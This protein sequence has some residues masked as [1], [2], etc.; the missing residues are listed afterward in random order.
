MPAKSTER[1]FFSFRSNGT[2]DERE[3]VEATVEKLDEHEP[4]AGAAAEKQSWFGTDTDLQSMLQTLGFP[5]L[6]IE[7][8]LSTLKVNKIATRELETSSEELATAGFAA[9]V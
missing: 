5:V 7:G 9:I 4:P 2:N 1:M 6:D 3:L 8:V